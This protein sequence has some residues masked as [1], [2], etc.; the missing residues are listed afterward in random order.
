MPSLSGLTMFRWPMTT[1]QAGDLRPTPE[2]LLSLL[3]KVMALDW[4]RAGSGN[5]GLADL[6]GLASLDV[7]QTTVMR[8][9]ENVLLG[10]VIVTWGIDGRSLT[11]FGL[12]SYEGDDAA[13]RV[14]TGYGAMHEL[15][16]AWVGPAVE[17]LTTM[18][19][20]PGAVWRDGA[21]EIEMHAHTVKAPALQINVERTAA[22]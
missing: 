2:E 19:S 22:A 20:Q 15:L 11:S 17:D 13:S 16:T 21:W 5:N 12:F 8:L 6:L 14:A 1:T 10:D 4:A 3:R 7:A 9:T 18:A